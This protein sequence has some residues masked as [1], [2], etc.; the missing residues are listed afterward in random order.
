[1]QYIYLLILFILCNVCSG[2]PPFLVYTLANTAIQAANR[3][4]ARENAKLQWM[5][6]MDYYHRAKESFSDRSYF[7]ARRYFSESIR[8]AEK[9]ENI[10]R[11]KLN[12]G[13]G[14]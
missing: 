3:S 6:A 14:I 5:K 2:R 7:S 12:A 13:N 1:M 10:S 11:L 4:R 8:W 9:A